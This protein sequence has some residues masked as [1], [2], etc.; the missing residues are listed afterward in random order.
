MTGV[1]PLVSMVKAIG[2]VARHLAEAAWHV[3]SRKEP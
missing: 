3:L 1:L 2:A